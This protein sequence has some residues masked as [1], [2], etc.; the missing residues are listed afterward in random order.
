[1]ERLVLVAGD[2]SGDLYASLLIGALRA[3]HPSVRIEAA[4]G[5][6]TRA[7]L[8]KDGV[9]LCDL[10]SMGV[11]GFVE[12]LRR[13]PFLLRSARR[14]LRAIEER[15]DALVCI[16]FYGFNRRL[17]PAAKRVGVP[18]H[19][20]VSPQ[21]WASR[22][23]RVR[24]LKR[25][26]ERMLVIFPFEEPL[27]RKAGVPVTWVGHPLLD[28]LPA[29]LAEREPV[30]VPRIGLLPGSR[31]SEVRRHLP[32]LLAAAA[33]IARDFP[34]S[35]FSV[36]AAP[37]LPDAAYAPPRRGGACPPPFRIVRESDYVQRSRLDLALTSS[38]TATLENAL[39]GVPMVVLYRLS[40]PTYL[41]ARSMVRVPYIAMA[42]LLAGRRLVPEL[43]QRDASPERIA[44]AALDLLGH[45]GRLRALGRELAL[46]RDALG[47]PGAVG[48][49]ADAI[50]GSV[51]RKAP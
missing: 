34:R 26:V 37:S 15:P 36:F 24:T 16:D 51:A 30:P 31:P 4:G 46:L 22:P 49:A 14:V 39:L 48:R 3:R 5:P 2:P 8:G 7:A 41:I 6:L 9:F 44:D 33:R 21:V 35:E 1:M 13:V 42:N 23:G 18:V 12:P 32:A 47:G 19:Y 29:P 20:F 17:L 40:W 43:I 25:W 11:T 27:Y 28:V 10:A 38:G 45:P 50:L